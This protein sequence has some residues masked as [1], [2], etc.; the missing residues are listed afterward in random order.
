M[1]EQTMNSKTIDLPYIDKCA[2]MKY[3]Y[4]ERNKMRPM[5]HK[6]LIQQEYFQ[7]HYPTICQCCF[8][9]CLEHNAQGFA[10][11]CTCICKVTFDI[12]LIM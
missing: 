10:W 5:L 7:Y 12:M 9:T 2:S 3:G 11:A 8:T 1:W 4:Q 6:L